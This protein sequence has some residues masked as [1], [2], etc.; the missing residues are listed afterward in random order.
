M[1]S[2]LPSVQPM[3]HA[4]TITPYG[5]LILTALA[6]R[7]QPE[8][9]FGARTTEGRKARA[10]HGVL[11]AARAKLNNVSPLNDQPPEKARRGSCVVLADA[12]DELQVRLEIDIVTHLAVDLKAVALTV[13]DDDPISL[14]IEVHRRRETEAPERLE[15]ARPTIRLHHVG[16]GV[17]ALL[18]PLRHHLGIA[19]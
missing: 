7:A 14:R 3:P 6:G 16:I 18:S 13:G 5:R 8:R 17:D 1:R 9:H 2:R 4:D 19:H 10:G 11:F 15:I 12:A